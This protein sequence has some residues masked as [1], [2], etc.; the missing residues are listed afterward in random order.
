MNYIT[1]INAF[2]D[3]LETNSLST[4]AITLW[5]ALMHINNKAAWRREFPVAVSVLCVKTGLAE[6]TIFKARNELKQ[7]GF[8]EFRSRRGNQAAV[9]KLADLSAPDAYNRAG[10]WVKNTLFAPDGGNRADNCADSHAGNPATLV[11]SGRNKTGN[12]TAAS[13]SNFFDSYMICF[14]RQPTPLLLD[15]ITDY[16]DN[17]GLSESLVCLA[18]EKASQNGKQYPYAR[19]ILNSWIKKGIKNVAQA[20]AE[21]KKFMDSKKRQSD[22]SGSAHVH[23]EPEPAWMKNKQQGEKSEHEDDSAFP[24]GMTTEERA[25]WLEAYMGNI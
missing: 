20:N 23:H 25:Q 6:R 19:S 1:Q 7:N 24:E 13:K 11:S 17:D 12:N 8:I 9:Y 2:Y 15:E 22:Q 16:I 14:G 18:F 3:R 21:Q 10:K 5:H 4:S